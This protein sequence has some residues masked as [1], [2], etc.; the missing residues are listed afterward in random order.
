MNRLDCLVALTIIKRYINSALNNKCS[1]IKIKETIALGNDA[2]YHGLCLK[3]IALLTHA[4]YFR[5]KIVF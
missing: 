4:L 3:I 5:T 2:Y 1:E